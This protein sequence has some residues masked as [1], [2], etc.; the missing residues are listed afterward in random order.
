MYTPEEKAARL[1][2]LRRTFVA[3]KKKAVVAMEQ[4]I[5]YAPL[6]NLVTIFTVGRSIKWDADLEEIEP[7]VAKYL[8]ALNG[9]HPSGVNREMY[10]LWPEGKMPVETVYTENP[11][12][13]YKHDPDYIPYYWEMLVDEAVQPKGMIV[14]CAGGDHGDSGLA[15]VY[16]VA[17]D[18]NELGYQCIILNN[19]TNHQPWSIRE[20]GV[21]AARCMR[22]VRSNCAKYRVPADRIAFAGFSNGGLTGEGIIEYYS[23]KQTVKDVFPSYEPDEYDAVD[24]TPS[25]FLCVYGPRYAGAPFNYENCVYPPVFFA[26]G[27]DDR[28]CHNLY[29]HLPDM[30]AHGLEIEIHTFAGVP[31]GQAGM[32]IVDGKVKY[33][34]FELWI[35]LADSFMTDLYAKQDA[36]K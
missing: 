23:G 17:M 27:R 5:N 29:D 21:D 34:T 4:C 31:H 13:R 3:A 8:E 33:P 15:E 1:A 20:A 22:I 11:D 25:A 9:L 19:R 2:E 16:R 10:P 7:K 12:G 18:F 28:A 24:A 32:K 6:E 26:V 30:L 14:L 35:P 36:K